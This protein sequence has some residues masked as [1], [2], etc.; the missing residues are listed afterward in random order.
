MLI[1]FDFISILVNISIVSINSNLL[2]IF[3]MSHF[4]ILHSLLMNEKSYEEIETEDA[5]ERDDDDINSIQSPRPQHYYPY[6]DQLSTL[7]KHLS[8]TID[9][10]DEE[11]SYGLKQTLLVNHSHL[12]AYGDN[13]EL[14]EALEA[15]YMRFE[16][17]L[18]RA[19]RSLLS[20]LYPNLD[21]LLDSSLST[22]AHSSRIYVSIYNLPNTIPVRQLRTDQVGRLSSISGTVTRTSDVRPELLIGAFRCTKCGLL[23]EHIQQQYSFTRP[24]TCRNPRCNNPNPSEFV[25]DCG[26]KSEFIDWQKLRVQENAHEIPPGSMPRSIDVVLRGE[27]VE[28]AK[29][30]DVCVFTGSLVVI[31]DGS[32]LARAG[33]SAIATRQN[34]GRGGGGGTNEAATGGGGGVRGL[35]A[36]GVKELTYKTCFVVSS[37][38]PADVVARGEKLTNFFWEHHGGVDAVDQTPQDVAME[39]SPAE[40]D[41]IRTMKSSPQLYSHVSFD[42]LGFTKLL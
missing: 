21:L 2:C 41:E 20:E 19:V 12:R 31:P 18:R 27:M 34:P 26:P 4:V 42:S 8:N 13:G 38:L 33:E 1:C 32:A 9:E 30:G 5:N 40:R 25:L 11:N 37:V 10:D 22:N 23:A 35:K 7:A 24:T 15:E 3:F 16:P 29:A 36:L 14:A 6:M 39:L 28:R 17:F